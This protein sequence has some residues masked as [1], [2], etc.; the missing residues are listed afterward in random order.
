M[1]TIEQS[2]RPDTYAVVNGRI[3]AT[4]YAGPGR[5]YDETHDYGPAT[6][7]D[8]A[9]LDAQECWVELTETGTGRGG[10]LA[11][12]YDHDDPGPDQL[13]LIFEPSGEYDYYP[14][15]DAWHAERRA[16]T[17]I[18]PAWVTFEPVIRAV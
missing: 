8:L 10:Y 9:A 2:A 13:T 14:P 6:P 16:V 4:F 12:D 11:T 18:V 7:A 1:N 5:P 15:A 3:M 17:A